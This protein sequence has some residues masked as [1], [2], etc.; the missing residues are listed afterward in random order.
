MRLFGGL[1]A[2]ALTAALTLGPASSQAGQGDK[3]KNKG[4]V[5]GTVTK[6]DLN[7]D[8]TGT[9]TVK[10]AAAKKAAKGKAKAKAAAAGGERTFRVTRDTK[11]ELAG[12]KKQDPTP[13]TSAALKTG[14]RVA[15]A[16]GGQG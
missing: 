10:V 15:V 16:A 1:L 12:K 2:A 7:P 11:F 8:G 6:V 13:A 3:K 14:A 4:T 5:R 9:F